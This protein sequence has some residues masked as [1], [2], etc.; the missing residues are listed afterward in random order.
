M[1]L[2]TALTRYFLRIYAAE[3]RER[4]R[5]TRLA[6]FSPYGEALFQ[7]FFLVVIAAFGI[8][9]AITVLLLLIPNAITTRMLEH[10]VEFSVAFAVASIIVSYLLVR[11]SVKEYRDAPKIALPFDSPRDRVIS[12]VQFWCVLLAA[13]AMPFATA[14]IIKLLR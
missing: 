1:T 10:R 14:E 3:L 4:P 11:G 13:V 5:K 9:G 6:I 8:G 12:N 7:A 2:G